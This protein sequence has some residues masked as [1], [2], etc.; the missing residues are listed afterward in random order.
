[1]GF[2]V[3]DTRKA[4]TYFKT[5]FGLKASTKGWH[6]CK[7]P[8]CNEVQDRKKFAIHFGYQ[9]A[10]CWICGYHEDIVTFVVDYEGVTPQ[11]A[12]Q[13]LQEQEVTKVTFDI[14]FESDNYIKSEVE[15]PIGFTPIGMGEG[16]LGVRAREYLKSR[17]FNIKQLDREGFGYCNAYADREDDNYFGYIIIPFKVMGKLVYYIGRD[18]IG[19]FLRYKNPAREKF[20]IGKSEVLFNQDALEMYDEAFLMEGWSDAKTWGEQGLAYLGSKLSKEQSRIILESDCRRLVFVPD[21]GVDG[22][23]KSFYEKGLEMASDFVNHKEVMVLDLNVLGPDV[24]VNSIGKDAVMELYKNA[25]VE[26]NFSIMSKLMG[27]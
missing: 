8:F 23:G 5:N 21:A 20:G 12:K 16:A 13:I 6:L 14:E 26:D 3:I 2:Y 18:F 25:E 27:L 1:M 15:L 10:K 22:Q 4:Y 17:G 19:N 7:C 24:D 9:W 11:Q